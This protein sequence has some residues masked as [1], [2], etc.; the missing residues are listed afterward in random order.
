MYRK[1]SG[2]TIVELLVVIVVIGILAA[3]SIV[4][5]NGIQERARSAETLTRIDAYT[6]ALQIY[7]AQ[8]GSFPLAPAS[9]TST[10]SVACLGTPDEYPTS[11]DFASGQCYKQNGNVTTTSSTVNTAVQSAISTVPKGGTPTFKSTDGTMT[12]RGILYV[13]GGGQYPMIQYI[14][15]GDQQ[16]C[17]RGTAL[18]GGTTWPGLTI[19]L[20][21]LQ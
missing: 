3:I 2:F 16:T 20:V 10:A 6:Q 18:A 5:Y 7:R 9:E 15:K 8:N 17:G 12:I 21:S 11:P 14:V 19:C 1:N 4:S 13:D